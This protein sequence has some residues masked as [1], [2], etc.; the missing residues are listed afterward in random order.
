MKKIAI[1]GLLSLG[2]A[3]AAYAQGTLV[4]NNNAAGTVVAHIWSPD[5]TTPNVQTT[6]NGSID[7][8]VGATVYNGMLIGGATGT[9]PSSALSAPYTGINYT[10]GNNFTAQI[11]AL[12]TTG[13]TVQPLGSLVP[14]SQ[15]VTTMRTATVSGAGPGFI[16]AV[17]PS[18]DPGI[19]NPN[20]AADSAS[21]TSIDNRATV[22]L[23]CWY[24]AGGTIT[25]LAQAVAA[26]VPEGES[27]AFNINNLGEP[28]SI[29]TAYNGVPTA[30]TQP[31]YMTH[32]TSF[33]LV[34][35]VPEPSTIALGV[36]GA[37]AFLARRRMKK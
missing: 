34:A 27:A 20:A 25:S 2:L 7:T 9:E 21:Q 22:A 32:L 16:I 13:S 33:D 5:P 6:G 26:G 11:Y 24:N 29:E 18:P 31:A 17:S 8:P 3:G 23:A 19:P 35:P 15:Y 36:L 14:V 12:W 28:S 37:C 4:F 1:I 10:F 30:A